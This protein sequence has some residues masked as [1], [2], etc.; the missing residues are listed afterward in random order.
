MAA[1][2]MLPTTMPATAPGDRP[3]LLVGMEEGVGGGSGWSG[4]SVTRLPF[5]PQPDMTSS[6]MSCGLACRTWWQQAVAGGRVGSS[7]GRV[8]SS[9]GHDELRACLLDL[10]AAGQAAA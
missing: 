4:S 3:E 8:G 2:A 7:R 9:G 5:T 1:P 6:M 10:V